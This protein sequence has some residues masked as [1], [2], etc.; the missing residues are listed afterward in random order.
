MAGLGRTAPALTADAIAALLACPPPPRT[1]R[2][3][4]P[5]LLAELAL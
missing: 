3:G 4:L 1:T 2:D 5:E